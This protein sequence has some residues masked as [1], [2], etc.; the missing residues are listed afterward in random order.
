VGYCQERLLDGQPSHWSPAMW[1]SF[2]LRRGCISTLA[3]ETQ[4]LQEAA[5]AMEWMGSLLC[6]AIYPEFDLHDREFWLQERMSGLMTDC[7]S[8]YDH[9]AAEI[10]P[11]SLHDKTAALDLTIL[12]SDLARLGAPLRWCPTER[13]LADGLTKDG[14]DGADL[15]RS[16]LREGRYVLALES[17]VLE[18]KQRE[19]ERRLKVGKERAA[20]AAQSPTGAG[21]EKRDYWL[22]STSRHFLGK[23]AGTL[24]SDGVEV[25]RIRM[26]NR[27]RKDT[28][29][30][31][32]C[33]GFPPSHVASEERVTL[34][35]RAL[36]DGRLG[37]IE[38]IRHSWDDQRTLDFSWTGAT[39]A[40]R[41]SP[42]H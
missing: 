16:V 40:L 34:Y 4:T 11:S 6:E 19:K 39:V 24:L 33:S 20:R 23:L 26:H 36:P 15:I 8:A 22:P 42:S 35:R 17:T 37:P 14:A 10:C 27:E 30:W 18:A 21:A 7:K 2:R 12:R 25:L 1:K 31:G 32:E 38:H 41:A 13:Q 5:R 29:K 3:A 28:L 9:L